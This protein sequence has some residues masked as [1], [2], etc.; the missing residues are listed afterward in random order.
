MKT[1]RTTR[2]EFS[3]DEKGVFQATQRNTVKT[4]KDQP[5]V[6]QV[7]FRWNGTRMSP[8]TTP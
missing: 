5:Q 6:T 8:V 2:V 7:V 4:E 1:L 3:L